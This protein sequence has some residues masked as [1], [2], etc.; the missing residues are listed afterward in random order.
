MDDVAR[1]EEVSSGSLDDE[2]FWGRVD[3]RPEEPDGVD[4]RRCVGRG[5]IV[6]NFGSPFRHEGEDEGAEGMGFRGGNGDSP[7]KF[8]LSYDEFSHLSIPSI[9]A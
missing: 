8:T 3:P 7:L 4:H 2:R 5:E 1:G 6:G 9:R